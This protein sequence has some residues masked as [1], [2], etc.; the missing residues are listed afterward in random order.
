MLKDKIKGLNTLKKIAK[1][2][3]DKGKRIAFTNGCFDL[4]HYGHAIYLE[5]AKKLGDILIVAV[6]SDSSVKKIKGCSRPV[7]N[8]KHRL[9]LL[10][11]QESVDY[12]VLFSEMTPLKVIKAVKPDIL[13][14]GADWSKDKIVGAGFVR[15]YGGKVATIKLLKGL[16]T[17]NLIKRIAELS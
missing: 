1:G 8:Q 17:S 15:G 6:N 12:V 16:S 4:L 10:A 5:Q 13:I 7:V 2:L 9:G 3:K 14:K 11:S